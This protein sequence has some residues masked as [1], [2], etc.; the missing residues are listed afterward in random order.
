MSG[1]GRD[2]ELL[3][4]FISTVC[5][6]IYAAVNE[7]SP[8]RGN[9]ACDRISAECAQWLWRLDGFNFLVSSDACPRAHTGSSID[10]DKAKETSVLDKQPEGGT[11]V[12]IYP[13]THVM[14]D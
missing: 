4:S 10:N 6:I 1:M 5:L 9:A 13:Y 2:P 14:T 8:M 12:S 3:P 11:I 7:A